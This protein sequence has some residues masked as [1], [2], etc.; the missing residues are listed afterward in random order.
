MRSPLGLIMRASNKLLFLLFLSW[1]YSCGEKSPDGSVNNNMEYAD[2]QDSNWDTMEMEE[3]S[4]IEKQEW[5]AKSENDN[6]TEYPQ[7]YSSSI[8]DLKI[9]HKKWDV[10]FLLCSDEENFILVRRVVETDSIPEFIAISYIE[11]ERFKWEFFFYHFTLDQSILNKSKVDG[12]DFHITNQQNFIERNNE[13]T[14]YHDQKRSKYFSYNIKTHE[15][16]STNTNTTSY[17]RSYSTH[18]N[19]YVSPD[20]KKTIELGSTS[21]VLIDNLKHKKNDTLIN[22]D[23]SG[24][25][26]IGDVSWHWNSDKFYFD[27]SGPVACIWEIDL[28]NRTIDKIVP[29]HSALHPTFFIWEGFDYVVYCED[30]CVKYSRIRKTNP[31]SN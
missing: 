10:G 14:F 25:W 31:N 17:S 24:N 30:Q 9:I 13:I 26:S 2:P 29:N 5:L 11:L 22:Q 12:A 28:T 3:P 16:K 19:K 4:P 23:Y 21:I 18:E 1:L 27:N 7:I 8:G 20:G 6:I 15:L